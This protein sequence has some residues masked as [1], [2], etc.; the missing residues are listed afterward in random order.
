MYNLVIAD[1]SCLIVLKKIKRLDLL[2]AIFT[3]V[4]ITPEIKDEFTEPLPNWI[5]V[6]EVSESSH[7]R[8]LQLELGKG[9]ASAIALGLM[10]KKS[11]LLLDDR[12][13]RIIA[14]KLNLQVLGTLGVLI[15]AK[16]NK[17]IL[18]LKE[19]IYKLKEVDFRMSEDLI[20]KILSNYE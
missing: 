2:K 13:A 19:E 10:N 15:K 9:E 8:F 18:S 20:Q 6:F 5:E 3:K 4:I 16:E 14:K 12:K 1:T 17:L 11:L 7:K